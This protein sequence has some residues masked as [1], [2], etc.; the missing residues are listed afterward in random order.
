VILLFLAY[1]FQDCF[2]WESRY[3]PWK[4][5]ACSVE[6][7]ILW[8]TPP[9]NLMFLILSTWLDWLV[10]DISR[11]YQQYH[12]QYLEIYS[13]IS[14]NSSGSS[15]ESSYYLTSSLFLVSFPAS[16]HRVPVLQTRSSEFH[17]QHLLRIFRYQSY[18]GMHLTLWTASTMILLDT[19]RN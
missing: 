11:C 5:A 4:A 9:R 7:H 15:S 8:A 12:C 6:N 16:I 2:S 1:Y 14:M 3:S 19:A 10:Q 18:T 13:H 17:L